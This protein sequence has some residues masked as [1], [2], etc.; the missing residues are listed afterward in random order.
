MPENTCANGHSSSGHQTNGRQDSVP[1]CMAKK[2]LPV[3]HRR[4]CAIYWHQNT[5]DEQTDIIG[6]EMMVSAIIKG[7]PEQCLEALTNSRCNN[8]ILGPATCVEV[9]Q[10]SA[11]CSKQVR[12]CLM[13]TNE[14]KHSSAN[15]TAAACHDGTWCSGVCTVCVA[16]SWPNPYCAW[17][18]ALS[19]NLGSCVCACALMCTMRVLMT[20]DDIFYD[21]C[22]H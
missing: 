9:L 8:S 4:G 14:Q 7:T 17:S 1:L 5:S 20:C 16:G 12:H 18:T 3:T 21:I 10:Q 11:D 6:G 22:L 19:C 2:W 13:I 15:L